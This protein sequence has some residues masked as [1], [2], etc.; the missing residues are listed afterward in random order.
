VNEK[1][2]EIKILDAKKKQGMDIK[3]SHI[4]RL[5]QQIKDWELKAHKAQVK[6]KQG[7]AIK[8]SHISRLES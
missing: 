7:L 6:L 2:Q 3:S 5:E 1:E 8:D 4:T